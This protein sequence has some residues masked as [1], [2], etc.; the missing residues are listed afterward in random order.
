MAN[1]YKELEI[2][3]ISLALFY[4]VHTLSLKLPKYELY[5]WEVK[6]EGQ[7]IQ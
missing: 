2:F 1:S 6:L 5:E 3:H 7:Q 4:K